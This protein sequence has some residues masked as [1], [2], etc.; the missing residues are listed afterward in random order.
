M[1]GDILNQSKNCSVCGGKGIVEDTK[2]T[3]GTKECEACKGMGAVLDNF[4]TDTL[5][6]YYPEAKKADMA[7]T[8]G[9]IFKHFGKK[10]TE[11]YDRGREDIRNKK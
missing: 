3:G 7:K 1:D 2:T 10:L 11:S 6:E 9:K 8:A 4:I 5:L